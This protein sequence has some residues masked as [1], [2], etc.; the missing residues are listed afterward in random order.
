VQSAPQQDG[1]SSAARIE[2]LQVPLRQFGETN[3]SPHAFA[4]RVL[5]LIAKAISVLRGALFVCDRSERL[6]LVGSIGLDTAAR[7]A[8][9]DAVASGKWNTPYNSLK[10]QRIVVVEAAQKSRSTPPALL[11]A[12]A[13]GT[14][15]LAALPIRHKGRP[16]GVLLLTAADGTIF[17]DDV[18]RA[19]TRVLHGCVSPLQ[20]LPDHQAG[21]RAAAGA[22]RPDTTQPHASRSGQRGSADVSF[23]K[24]AALL[25]QAL[26]RLPLLTQE[27][28]RLKRQLRWSISATNAQ[29]EEAERLTAELEAAR[30]HIAEAEI[31]A[32][33][34]E[35]EREKR[36]EAA[37]E[38]AELRLAKEA[39][40][41]AEMAE[42][43]ATG[44]EERRKADLERVR[45][46]HE[47]EALGATIEA[48]LH[49][50][51]NGREELAARVHEVE[52]DRV[53]LREALE[54]AGEE[55]QALLVRL[56]GELAERSESESRLRARIEQLAQ[57]EAAYGALQQR[58]DELTAALDSS[59]GKVRELEALI[60]GLGRER[61]RVDPDLLQAFEQELHESLAKVGAKIKHAPGGQPDW[62]ALGQLFGTIAE[63]SALVGE[64]GLSEDATRLAEMI[65]GGSPL[66]ADQEAV[67][68][69][70]ME[71]LFGRVG[72]SA[73]RL[74]GASAVAEWRPPRDPDIDT[75]LLEVFAI[76]AGEELE[77]SEQ[78]LLK[79]E[80]RPTDKE[81]IYEIFRSFHTLKGAA[82]AVGLKTLA[83][84]LHHGETLLEAISNGEV[85][86]EG[87][88]LVDFC[89]RLLDSV[90]A[91]LE[92]A[93][94]SKVEVG[95]IIRNVEHEV[96]LLGSVSSESAAP[97]E[98]AEPLPPEEEEGTSVGVERQ[99]A[100]V[101]VVRV[102]A[103]RLAD[104]TNDVGRL[105]S[106]RTE[107]LRDTEQLAEL[108]QQ[109]R[110]AP[111]ASPLAE[112]FSRVV[113]RLRCR[114]REFASVV[115][116]VERT[117]EG[118]R[119]APL[120]SI[121]RRLSRPVRDAA[122][123]EGKNVQFEAS[124]GDVRVDSSICDALHASLLH[125]VRNSVAHGIEPP[126]VREARGKP[127]AGRVRIYASVADDLVT[128]T[129][130]DDGGG[131]N[132][133][134]ILE[135]GR[136]LGLIDAEATP[137]RAELQALI[138]HPGFSTAETTSD[139]A[140]RGVGMDVV[141]REV[142]A[143]N[144]NIEIA[145]EPGRGTRVTFT[146]PL[147]A[148]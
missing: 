21:A 102:E 41:A 139:L 137:D 34:V 66:P 128:L 43:W 91:L 11:P 8:L 99:E 107:A 95:R 40:R 90:A 77:A 130:E 31:K 94:G 24:K 82:A 88:K 51:R 1:D 140:G 7:T 38:A 92:Y 53:Q 112:A 55:S 50:Q 56:R 67:A 74:F 124:N 134:R 17:S 141:A 49:E 104:L 19:L 45:S 109:L 131:I 35:A 132:F 30:K 20:G 63:S 60:E 15:A 5:A 78:V 26:Q 3:P 29:K 69:Q 86:V 97:A 133:E 108:A 119:L 27:V 98:E 118:L 80:K 58:S 147:S 23:E 100:Q 54:R 126:A 33:Q 28:D 121:F 39:K 142:A 101:A 111:G 83:A 12:R 76:E 65:A 73:P 18:L 96:S 75:E 144:G 136:R 10:N 110:S 42:A 148:R 44:E 48:Q 2:A 71:R 72:L 123:Q 4:D 81:L 85:M 47:L 6:A 105:V 122:R 93:Q 145:S 106:S 13:D 115:D 84:Q 125:V 70:C 87:E 61:R 14:V 62:A 117:L 135:K 138:F 113:E 68:Q 114:G 46:Q 57:V 79:L 22:Q 120:E 146:L 64:V 116:S 32:R 52:R 25:R 37:E 103:G 143:L 59:Q 9:N 36:L 89:L 16:L 127:A 129:V